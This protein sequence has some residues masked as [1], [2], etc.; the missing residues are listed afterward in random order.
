MQKKR[1]LSSA[2]E[3][4][5][6]EI[7]RLGSAASQV[8]VTDL[9]SALQVSAASATLMI[10]KLAT[11]GLVEHAPYQPVQLT[12]AGEKV[13]LELIRHHRL[14]EL[15]LNEALGIPWDEVHDEAHRLEHVLSD[16]LENRISEFL[17]NPTRD[18][19]GD[20]IPAKDGTVP[21][22]PRQVLADLAPG[23]KVIVRRVGIQDPARL[24]YLQWMGLVPGVSVELIEQAP[25]DGPLRVRV[26]RQSEQVLDR[27]LALQIWVSKPSPAHTKS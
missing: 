9:A 26:E 6:Q 5:V 16:S 21:P 20:P 27:A 17:G 4:Y 13:A 8:T 19:H 23:A 3:D 15:F 2:A 18:P 7:Y 12:R 14:L 22:G 1:M 11:L 10:K 24:R 25:F